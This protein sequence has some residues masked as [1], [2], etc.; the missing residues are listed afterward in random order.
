[1]FARVL[2]F[3]N[4]LSVPHG[5]SAGERF[6][7]V[8]SFII[9]AV[10]A[11]ALLRLKLISLEDVLLFRQDNPDYVC[12]LLRYCIS[13]VILLMLAT[14]VWGGALIP[15]F[16]V[17]T[18]AFLTLEMSATVRLE[19][20]WI[21]ILR[22]IPTTVFVSAFFILAIDSAVYS[23][24]LSAMLRGL[25]R[26]APV[27]LFKHCLIVLPILALAAAFDSCLIPMI[28]TRYLS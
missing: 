7:I 13:V 2:R 17:L 9:G 10:A 21:V 15:L 12:A 6:F 5:G 18:A 26:P 4:D 19:F 25:P 3:N 20:V 11:F 22:G 27:P 1:M 23:R 28:L 16:T 24:D 8:I 14:S